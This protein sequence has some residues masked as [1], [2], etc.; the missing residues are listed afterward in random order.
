MRT[1]SPFNAWFK[2][3]HRAEFTWFTIADSLPALTID[4]DAAA[5]IV[6]DGCRHGDAY[7]AIGWPARVGVVANAIAPN[8]IAAAS[9]L[10]N[11]LV[12]PD[13]VADGVGSTADSAHSGWQSLSSWAPSALTRLTERAARDNNEVPGDYDAN[14]VTH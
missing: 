9:A 6:I 1:G 3:D 13:R 2:G 12:L 5:D 14:D 7:R 11:R 8:L 10:A 4:A